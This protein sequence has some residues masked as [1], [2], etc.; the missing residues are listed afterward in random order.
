MRSRWWVACAFVATAYL[1]YGLVLLGVIPVAVA[2][3]RRRFRPL[4]VAAAVGVLS[5]IVITAVTGFAWWDGAAATRDRYFAGV[6][7]NRPYEY[8]LLG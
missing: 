6:G 3:A 1:S 8:F 7:R 2:V 4:V 5:L